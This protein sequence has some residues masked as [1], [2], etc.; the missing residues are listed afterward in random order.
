MCDLLWLRSA[1][2]ANDQ[3]RLNDNRFVSL[4]LLIGRQVEREFP[5]GFTKG[6]S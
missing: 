5:D 6:A 1:R 3:F 4:R 2:F